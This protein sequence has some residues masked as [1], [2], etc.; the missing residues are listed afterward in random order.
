MKLKQNMLSAAVLVLVL[1]VSLSLTAFAHDV[2][3]MER[4]CSVTIT[5]HKGSEIVSGGTLTIYQVGEIV[6]ND[7]N[8][9]FRPTGDFAACGESFESLDAASEIAERLKTYAV[10]SEITG[11][12]TEEIGEDGTVT[13]DT[14]PVG[15]YL[16]VQHQA[17][18]G[19]AALPPFLVSLPYME[20]GKYEYDLSAFP[21]PG[22][23]KEPE[24]TD[25]PPTTPPGPNLPQ[26]G[27]L[28]WPVPVLAVSG[29]ALFTLG[30]ML[31]ANRR[32]KHEG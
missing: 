13:F 30:W 18:P 14:L 8:Y 15:L 3:D 6:E 20:N 17:A 2:P 7:G 12:S 5:T 9:S 27:Q 23:E 21:K 29:M 16:I 31:F 28:N 32:K 4:L 26:T 10:V 1:L 24:P 25:P 11:L 19:Y 22:L